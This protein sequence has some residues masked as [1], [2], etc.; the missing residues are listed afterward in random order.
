MAHF[1]RMCCEARRDRR[2]VPRIPLPEMC[3]VL[4]VSFVG[5]YAWTRGGKSHR[6]RLAN[7]WEEALMKS[8][9]AEVKGAYGSRRMHHERQT[10]RQ[11]H[12]PARRRA[13]RALELIVVRTQG[14]AHCVDNLGP[15]PSA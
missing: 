12:R 7:A 5:H 1:A 9:H 3:E 15:C 11:P 4:A 10:K 14:R 6:N 8:V 13:L 2:A